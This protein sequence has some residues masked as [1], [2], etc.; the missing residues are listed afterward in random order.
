MGYSNQ[1][2]SQS[3]QPSKCPNS[4]TF[5]WLAI[6]PRYC[7]VVKRG[8]SMFSSLLSAGKCSVNVDDII[9]SFLCGLLNLTVC[10][11]QLPDF[12]FTTRPIMSWSRLETMEKYLG[13]IFKAAASHI[14]PLP[15]RHIRISESIN[16]FSFVGALIL[17]GYMNRN[18]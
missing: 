11:V 17:K 8:K 18:E 12:V 4:S 3:R 6:Y 7:F 14:S 16:T 2:G 10:M 1:G 9:D 5:V 13:N 15:I